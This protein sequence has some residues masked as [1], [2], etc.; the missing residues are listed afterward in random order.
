VARSLLFVLNTLTAAEKLRYM[1]WRNAGSA[2]SNLVPT[3]LHG[4]ASRTLCRYCKS[5]QSFIPATCETGL[6]KNLSLFIYASIEVDIFLISVPMAWDSLHLQI[7]VATRL[8][9]SFHELHLQLPLPCRFLLDIMN[10]DLHLFKQ[11]HLYLAYL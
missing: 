9:N 1:L 2:P 7:T 3:T 8:Q 10:L 5:N 4:S 11:L 6:L